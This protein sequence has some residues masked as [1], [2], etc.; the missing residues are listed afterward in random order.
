MSAWGA[1]GPEGLVASILRLEAQGAPAG[2]WEA[3]PS[4][5]GLVSPAARARDAGV[6]ASLTQ[7]SLGATAA[8]THS[9]TVT[10]AAPL[11]PITVPARGP[12]RFLS[13]APALGETRG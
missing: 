6:R 2:R 10:A 4:G 12:R 13:P 7:R 1:G 5:Q 3:R 9:P 11:G 8:K